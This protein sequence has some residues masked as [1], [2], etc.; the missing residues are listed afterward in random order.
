MTQVKWAAF[1]GRSGNFPFVLV[2]RNRFV[3]FTKHV[4]VIN[5][6]QLGNFLNPVNLRCYPRD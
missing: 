3:C 5:L 2:L 4:I 6:V 1:D